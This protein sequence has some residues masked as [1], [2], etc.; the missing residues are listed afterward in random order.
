MSSRPSAPRGPWTRDRGGTGVVRTSSRTPPSG[1]RGIEQTPRSSSQT[2]TDVAKGRARVHGG[3]SEPCVAALG[4][5][6]PNG[7]GRASCAPLQ[8]MDCPETKADVPGPRGLQKPLVLVKTIVHIMV[9]G[10]G[11]ALRVVLKKWWLTYGP[12]WNTGPTA[13]EPWHL[14]CKYYDGWWLCCNPVWN[15]CQHEPNLNQHLGRTTSHRFSCHLSPSAGDGRPAG[16]RSHR[17][18]P[19][20]LT[21][22]VGS[23]LSTTA[24]QQRW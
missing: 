6:L 5:T 1:A 17:S 4:Q 9:H 24:A 10:G 23:A 15:T 16:R 20:A 7:Q 18:P 8:A 21:I 12:A 13:S 19:A 3:S 11:N 2:T 22:G 14:G